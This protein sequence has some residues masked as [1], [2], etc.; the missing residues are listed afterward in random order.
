MK[1]IFVSLLAVAF[2][3]SAFAQEMN[4]ATFNVR[5]G[6]PRKSAAAPRKG[7]YK[8]YNGWDDRKQHLC[9]MINFEEIGRAHV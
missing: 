2:T 9:D 7:D 4:V 8:K 3:L 6:G 1:R 5:C